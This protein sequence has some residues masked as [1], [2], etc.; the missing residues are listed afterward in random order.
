MLRRRAHSPEAYRDSYCA[1]PDCES[2]VGYKTVADG[3]KKKSRYCKH[4]TCLAKHQHI[5]GGGNFCSHPKNRSPA[6]KY[7][8]VHRKCGGEGC[9]ESGENNVNELPWYCARHQCA[10][11]SCI[12]SRFGYSRFCAGHLETCIVLNCDGCANQQVGRYRC[13][14]H[15]ACGKAG[16]DRF[17][18][19]DRY[20][21][22]TAGYCEKHIP[23]QKEDCPDYVAGTDDDFCK[24]HKCAMSG[25]P[26]AR[27]GR[28]QFCGVHTCRASSCVQPL[29]NLESRAARF[30]LWHQCRGEGCADRA[31]KA[32]GYCDLHGC[33]HEE[34]SAKRCLESHYYCE[35][36][37]CRVSGCNA[38]G[39]SR[40]QYC[41]ANKHACVEQDCKDKRLSDDNA[42]GLC[43]PHFRQH[44]EQQAASEAQRANEER[45]REETSEKE[46]H[47]RQ[48]EQTQRGAEQRE[49]EEAKARRMA[50]EEAEAVARVRR[51]EEALA[52][53]AAERRACEW[54]APERHA[55]E[56][57]RSRGDGGLRRQLEERLRVAAENTARER[58]RSDEDNRLPQHA[59]RRRREHGWG[60]E[61][62]WS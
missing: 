14:Y 54:H 18:I 42:A 25:C 36:H 50:R 15:L 35:D 9:T 48:N 23:C 41:F 44:A 6:V 4:H 39:E 60:R 27:E 17:Q 16:C 29:S 56:R 55:H 13:E 46:R 49:R 8:N 62:A 3:E 53:S 30:C 47:R 31:R 33:A 45:V 32:G 11:P 34:C 12:K 58:L 28:S 22:G 59:A 19:R 61:E 40:G 20:G 10:D 7:C 43:V 51:A 1:V 57:A 52:R 21:D 38:E 26:S 5:I 24:H 37:R 2:K